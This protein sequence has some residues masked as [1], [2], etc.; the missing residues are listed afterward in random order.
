MAI[1]S[2]LAHFAGNRLILHCTSPPLQHQMEPTGNPSSIQLQ[3]LTLGKGHN[4]GHF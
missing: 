3:R 2:R 1:A 4:T